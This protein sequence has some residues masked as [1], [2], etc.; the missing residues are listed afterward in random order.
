VTTRERKVVAFGAVIV[1]F[2]VVARSAPA[3]ASRYLD[4]RDRLHQQLE[5]EARAAALIAAQ[6]EAQAA[7]EAVEVTLDSLSTILIPGSDARDAAASLSALIGGWALDNS[8]TVEEM[9]GSIDST[10][11]S[12]TQ[13]SMQFTTESDLRGWF[14]WMER[15]ESAP[16]ALIVEDLTITTMDWYDSPATRIRSQTGLVAWFQAEGTS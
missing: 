8:V 6:P 10:A 5:L 13:L 4:L 12:L 16:I 15:I 9:Q 2:A 7:R 3:A 14:G 11:G 1:L